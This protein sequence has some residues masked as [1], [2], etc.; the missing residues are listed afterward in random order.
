MEYVLN[1]DGIT[2][3]RRKLHNHEAKS[4]VA[5]PDIETFL[6]LHACSIQVTGKSDCDCIILLSFSIHLFRVDKFL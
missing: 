5:L 1:I 3:K 4:L 6:L 2:R